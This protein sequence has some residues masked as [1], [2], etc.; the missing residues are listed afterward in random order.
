MGN[1]GRCVCN[2]VSVTSK[3][4][5]QRPLARGFDR[6]GSNMDRVWSTRSCS[7]GVSFLFLMFL[8]FVLFVVVV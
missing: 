8:Y 5:L 3:L 6:V 4:K 1:V 7:S 2:C